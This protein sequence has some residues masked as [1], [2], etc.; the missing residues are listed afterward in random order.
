MFILLDL[1]RVK[2]R[3]ARSTCCQAR[4]SKRF[5]RSMAGRARRAAFQFNAWLGR[6]DLFSRPGGLARQRFD[7]TLPTSGL[8]AG[9]VIAE[10]PLMAAMRAA[11]APA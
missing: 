1:T 7:P 8:T 4:P 11:R 10:L 9:R 3:M 6:I 5:M 2:S